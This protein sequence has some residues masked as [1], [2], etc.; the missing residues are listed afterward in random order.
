MKSTATKS[1]GREREREN[2][3]GRLRTK[4][5]MAKEK[6]KEKQ[7]E[8][9]E[10][11]DGGTDEPKGSRKKENGRG[12][13]K[14][15][16]SQGTQ[17]VNGTQSHQ[18]DA[19]RRVLRAAYRTLK[20]DGVKARDQL[21]QIGSGKL[22]E[23]M[24]K[25][26]QLSENVIKTREQAIDA[27]LMMQVADYAEKMVIKHNPD[28]VI[29]PR[30]FL[31]KLAGKYL[32]S[33]EAVDELPEKPDLFPWHKLGEDVEHL[34]RRPGTLSCMLGPISSAPKERRL[35]ERRQRDVIE[36]K[37]APDD[38][39]TGNIASNAADANDQEKQMQYVMRK[40]KGRTAARLPSVLTEVGEDGF[41][42]TVEN[43]FNLSFLLR[44]GRAHLDMSCTQAGKDEES[45][46]KDID[47]LNENLDAPSVMLRDRPS[48]SDWKTGDAKQSA[49][50]M[51]FDMARY[52]EWLGFVGG[53]D[54]EENNVSIMGSAK[55]SLHNRTNVHMT[56]GVESKKAR[57]LL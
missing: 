33:L 8:S 54:K 48:E 56:A 53:I 55:K 17:A 35:I 49:F 16:G 9:N 37:A 45:A 25:V 38:V 41:T 28:K 43:L 47:V 11:Q 50:V 3:R 40:I 39:G 26:E 19:E 10:D 12:T 4:E 52:R 51:Q 22:K 32:V 42:K 13:N 2:E 15:R 44:D 23:Y 20:D 31:R 5:A 1:S 24:N 46:T 6:G 7:K 14:A 21:T 18:S 30:D 57:R 29:N 34:F 27:E 36:P